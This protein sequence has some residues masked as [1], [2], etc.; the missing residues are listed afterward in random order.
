M[1]FIFAST[2]SAPE[3]GGCVCCSGLAAR[4]ASS[5][6]ALPV[7][8]DPNSVVEIRSWGGE[9]TYRGGWQ[10]PPANCVEMSDQDFQNVNP[11]CEKRKT[12]GNKQ[13]PGS[14]SGDSA[15]FYCIIFVD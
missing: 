3:G 15:V 6:P 1:C 14:K 7:P 12:E 11:K 13:E 5:R 4:L 10:P 2:S 8:I 9:R